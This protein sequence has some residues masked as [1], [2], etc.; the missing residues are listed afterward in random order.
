MV[1]GFL[2]KEGG[3]R[4]F[5]LAS[6][7]NKE[8]QKNLRSKLNHRQ[9]KLFGS[10]LDFEFIRRMYRNKEIR[11]KF[12]FL[13]ERETKMTYLVFCYLLSLRL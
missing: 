11:P 2:S 12:H 4:C 5:I 9:H 6:D 10:S 3:R 8:D 1:S 13:T 7:K